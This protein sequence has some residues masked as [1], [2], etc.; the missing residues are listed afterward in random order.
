MNLTYLEH[1]NEIVT[2]IH[3]F[4]GIYGNFNW[5]HQVLTNTDD[6]YLLMAH[7]HHL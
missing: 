4:T 1:I 7:Y 2:E 6:I 3:P 5:A